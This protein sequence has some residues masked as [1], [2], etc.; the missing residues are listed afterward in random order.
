M[1]I[2]EQQQVLCRPYNKKIFVENFRVGG[3][4]L[5]VLPQKFEYVYIIVNIFFVNTQSI[6]KILASKCYVF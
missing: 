3:G 2:L 5:M 1:N 4:G 6:L